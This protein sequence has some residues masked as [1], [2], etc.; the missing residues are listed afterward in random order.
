MNAINYIIDYGISDRKNDLLYKRLSSGT[1]LVAWPTTCSVDVFL[2]KW[3]PESHED[4][5]KQCVIEKILSFD[6][7]DTDAVRA[8]KQ[9]INPV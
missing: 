3:L 7:T 4:I 1:Y 2:C 6:N 5:T 8:F 9:M